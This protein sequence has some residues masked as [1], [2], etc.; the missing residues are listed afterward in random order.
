MLLWCLAVCVCTAK[1]NLSDPLHALHHH[2]ILTRWQYRRTLRDVP[3]RVKLPES[4]HINSSI[5]TAILQ[6]IGSW[7]VTG[8]NHKPISMTFHF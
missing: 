7:D 5:S 6:Q 3:R 8:G 2:L 4:A 1:E